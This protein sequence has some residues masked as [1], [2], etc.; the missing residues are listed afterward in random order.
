MNNETRK[1]SVTLPEDAWE[2]VEMKKGSLAMSAYFREV[3]LNNGGG[4]DIYFVDDEHERNFEKV[5]SRWPA[6]KRNVEYMPACYILAVPMI[7]EKVESLIN[8]FENPTDWIWRWE[9][10]YT[11][12]KLPEYQD[13]DDD[14]ETEIPYDLTGSMVQ[15]GKFALNMWNGYE[16]FNLMD[17]IS[18]L[19][20]Q[21]YEVVR[22]AMDMR[23]G[24][25]K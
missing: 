25:F 11:M 13:S 7:F 1:I 4:K 9:W 10:R 5:L 18:R 24:A 6:G 19:D 3:I 8:D 21:N 2:K 15:L 20:E 14:E 17:C 16:H 12:S 22:C 23:M